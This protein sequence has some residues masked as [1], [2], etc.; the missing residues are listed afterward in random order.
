VFYVRDNGIGIAEEFHEDIFRIFKRLNSEDDDK[1]GTG[2]GL[3][4]VH[5]IAERHGGRILARLFAWERRHLLFH[6]R[7][8]TAL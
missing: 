4:F 3:S 8:R 2:V 7:T 5:K 1:K 6:D